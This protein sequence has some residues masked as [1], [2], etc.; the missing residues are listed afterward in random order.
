[1][2]AT[3]EPNA[4]IA[5]AQNSGV[6]VLVQA[7]GAGALIGTTSNHPVVFRTNDQDRVTI[8]TS[9]NLRVT[10]DV[11]LTNADCAEDFDV[12]RTAVVDPGTVMVLGEEGRLEHSQRAYDR[13]V[14]GVISG[15]G[16][17]RPAIVLD[18][19]RRRAI[20]RR[21]RWSARSTAKWTRPTGRSR[22]AIC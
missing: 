9:G 6:N 5:I 3:T 4:G 7:S 10:G 11:I 2:L 20:A 8:D 13:R 1:M 17:Y 12:A 22:S 18:R 15:A 16:S 21:S 14:A 19:R